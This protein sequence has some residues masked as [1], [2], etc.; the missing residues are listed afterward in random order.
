M[1]EKVFNNRMRQ[2]K[3]P[4]SWKE[5]TLI[6]IPKPDRDPSSPTSY[7]PIALLNQ[8]YKTFTGV[9]TKRLNGIIAQYEA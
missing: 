2:S 8:Y 9:L 4:D 5:A 1:L 3:I 7:C 6:A